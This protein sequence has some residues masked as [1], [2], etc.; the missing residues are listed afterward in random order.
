LYEQISEDIPIEIV[1]LRARIIE[2]SGILDINQVP[3][4][5]VENLAVAGERAV[6]HAVGLGQIETI[7]TPIVLRRE[8]PAGFTGSGPMLIVEEQTTTV[9]PRNWLVEVVALG[10]LRLRHRRDGEASGN[11]AV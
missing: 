3:S 10:V 9:V 4:G 2:P 6:S 1:T 11:R 7:P 8:L 5:S